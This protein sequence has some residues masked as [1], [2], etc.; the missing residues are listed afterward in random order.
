MA[1]CPYGAT[2]QPGAPTFFTFDD[3]GL[4]E[5]LP[6]FAGYI[7]LLVLGLPATPQSTADF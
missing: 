1:L 3:T 7:T 5:A 4:V 2:P 6:H